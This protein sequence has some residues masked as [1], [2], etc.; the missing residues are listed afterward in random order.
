MKQMKHLEHILTTY[1]Y[2]HCN[3]C[4]IRMKHMQHPNKTAETL[5]T[6]TCNIRV[7]QLQHMQY[8]DLLLHH[9]FKTHETYTC[10]MRFLPFFCAT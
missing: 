7:Q 10:N 6:D 5:G 9:P 3:R 4:N 8:P 2:S 1:V